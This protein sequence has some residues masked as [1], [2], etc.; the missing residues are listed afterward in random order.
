VA[1]AA[2]L[3][4]VNLID[5][6]NLERFPATQIQPTTS[7]NALKYYIE[8]DTDN[9]FTILLHMRNEEVVKHFVV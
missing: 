5:N 8:N 1:S 3:T 4:S 2:K 9:L 6:K 7:E